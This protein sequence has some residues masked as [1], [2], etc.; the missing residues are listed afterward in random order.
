MIGNTK[1]IARHLMNLVPEIIPPPDTRALAASTIGEMIF[2]LSRLRERDCIP[3][4]DGLRVTTI[5]VF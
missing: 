3:V 1:N 2:Y 5:A 4:A